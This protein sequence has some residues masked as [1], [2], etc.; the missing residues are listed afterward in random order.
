M[1]NIYI[2]TVPNEEIKKRKGFTGADWWWDEN[3]D[4]QVR[5]A[6]ELKDWRRIA[7]LQIHEAVEALCTKA[8]GVTV[9]QVDAFDRKFE[10]THP[11][12]HG[13]EAG[14]APGCPYAREHTAA[15]AC[16]RVVF[17]ELDAG[18]WKEYDDAVGKL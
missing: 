10:A 4:L 1:N 7:S 14:D 3:G 8:H 11:D 5:V 9:A 16:E 12:N 13:I 18:S 2:L 6:A 17:M 15:T